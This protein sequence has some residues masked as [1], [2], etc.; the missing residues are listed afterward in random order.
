MR[1]IAQVEKN[2]VRVLSHPASHI[3]TLGLDCNL[4][5]RNSLGLSGNYRHRG[6]TR[7]ESSV[8]LAANA[9]GFV[10][11][12]YDRVRVDY[13][14]EVESGA[15]AFYEHDFRKDDH[16]LRVEINVAHSP[17]T[18][19]NHYTNRYRTP[20]APLHLDNMLIKQT[21][22]QRQVTVDYSNA[23]TEH[24]TLEGGYSGD[25]N[26][27][28]MDNQG[29]VFDAAQQRFALDA[30]TSSRFVYRETIHAVYGTYGDTFGRV[31]VLGGLRMEQSFLHAH[32]VTGEQTVA[33]DYIKPYPTLH[34]AYKLSETNELQLNYSRRANRPE[35]EDLN[36]FPEYVDPRNVR[37]GNPRLRPELIHSL[38]LGCR[39][40]N[41]SGSLVPSVFYRR[42][43]DG[44]TPVTEALNDSTLLTTR[45]NLAKDESAGLELVL[46]W[47]SGGVLSTNASGSGFY[48]VID[49]SN[50]GF[51]AKKSTVTWSGT[52]SSN[53]N[54][55]S[56]TMLQLNS[57]YR[58]SR[59]TPQ[60][61][62]LA[63]VVFNVG[64]RQ[65][66]LRDKLSVVLTVSDLF[67][68]LKR[69]MELDTFWL[70][71]TVVT[72][73]DSRIAYLGV[74]YHLGK[75]AKKAKEKTLQYDNGN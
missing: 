59:L 4:D 20:T 34:L 42:K 10:T 40:Q 66:L 55:P 44:I 36:P 32:L 60:G 18:E 69:K 3:G 19:D 61:K 54:L 12:D 64:A 56:G 28:D 68:T 46:G 57:T 15:N 48:E 52:L 73:R 47:N 43:Y 39:L 11:S 31:S 51:G 63:S 58:S 16:T 13:E 35:G 75:P 9:G 38:E 67:K 30:A 23:L 24:S 1:L 37:V 2:I 72:N 70:K 27:T 17:E 6:F 49:A 21:E 41:K 53:L 62:S 25:F 26:K 33:N 50:L 74:A 14:S 22:D 29:G 8:N 71:Q 65:E 45:K 7:R 5:S